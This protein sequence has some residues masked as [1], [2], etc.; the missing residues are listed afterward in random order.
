M[1]STMPRIKQYD[2][3]AERQSAYRARQAEQ[4]AAE[5]GG[6][7]LPPPARINSM[8]SNTRWGA[9]IEHAKTQLETSRDEMQEYFDSRSEHWQETERAESLQEKIEKIVEILNIIDELE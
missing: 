8:P 3:H 9:L 5:R 1:L 4:R 2:S 6:K 7:L